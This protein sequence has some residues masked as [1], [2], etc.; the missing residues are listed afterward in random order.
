VSK[1]P[2]SIFRP[3]S[4]LLVTELPPARRELIFGHLRSLSADDRRLRF[5][6]NLSDPALRAYVRSIRFDRDCAFG[7]FDEHLELIGFGHLSLAGPEAEFGLSVLP[8]A[9]GRGVGLRLMR[10]AVRHAQ[11]HGKSSFLMTYLPENAALHA[12]AR[13]AGMT[14]ATDIDGGTGR[15]LLPAPPADALWHEAADATLTAL[16]LS[17]RLARRRATTSA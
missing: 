11:A 15:L 5:G 2:F 17:F 3:P 10:R 9:R 14:L 8:A 4:E 6:M 7:A 1:E 16:D 12:L 13:R